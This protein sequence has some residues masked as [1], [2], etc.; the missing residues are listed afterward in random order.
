MSQCKNDFSS[1][2]NNLHT[3]LHAGSSQKTLGFLVDS[4]IDHLDKNILCKRMCH[5]YPFPL[6]T[7]CDFQVFF[8]GNINT[9]SEKKEKEKNPMSCYSK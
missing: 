2:L 6:D 1:S 4:L 3:A 5:F 9:D 8:G 7:I